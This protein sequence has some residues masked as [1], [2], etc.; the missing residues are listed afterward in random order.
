MA[1]LFVN[2]CVRGPRSRTLQ[3]C[4]EYLDGL[5]PVREIDLGERTSRTLAPLSA[6]QVA[7]RTQLQQAGIFDD[8][9]F[10]MAKQFAA[11]EDI[12]IGA[13]YWDLSF[14]AVLKVYIENVSVCDITFGYSETGAYLGLCKA[15]RIT[16]ITSAGGYL[17]DANYGYDYICA[18][19]KMFGIPEVRLI[20]AEGLD[21]VGNDVNAAMEE[22]RA[23]IAEL[24]AADARAAAAAAPADGDAD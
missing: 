10:D 14:P 9:I 3:L 18:I 15:K 20:A 11:A 5:G 8:K 21:I 1:I 24:K 6:E 19:A 7:F 23:A 2:A 4:R 22:A 12:V 13:P 16:Y 17:D